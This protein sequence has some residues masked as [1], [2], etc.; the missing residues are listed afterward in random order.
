VGR[1][2]VRVLMGHPV[3]HIRSRRQNPRDVE[4]YVRPRDEDAM[5]QLDQND[6]HA[7]ARLKLRLRYTGT[8]GRPPAVA[9]LDMEHPL[10]FS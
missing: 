4:N 9:P 2:I 6:R 3:A 5:C 7:V 8:G 10:Q 1:D